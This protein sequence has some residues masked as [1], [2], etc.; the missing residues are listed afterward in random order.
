MGGLSACEFP[1]DAAEY[2]V[3][4]LLV[5]EFERKL[6][7]GDLMVEV[8][9]TIEVDFLFRPC[10]DEQRLLGQLVPEH[11]DVLLRGV[12]RYL[13][14]EFE[15]QHKEEVILEA[16][17]TRNALRLLLLPVA[18]LEH[19]CAG[20][21]QKTHP[22]LPVGIGVDGRQQGLQQTALKNFGCP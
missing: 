16:Q 11:F 9:A 4:A 2:L 12:V 20:T 5:R 14:D 15:V 1:K 13:V 7:G 22:L 17:S 3:N 6:M 21:A 19:D 10:G 18:L 8:T